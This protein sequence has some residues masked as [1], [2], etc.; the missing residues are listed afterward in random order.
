ML[1]LP[2][3]PCVVRMVEAADALSMY[4]FGLPIYLVGGALTDPDPR[5]I[6]LRVPVPDALFLA[7]YDGTEA[8][9]GVLAELTPCWRRWARDCATQSLEYTKHCRRLVD[10]KTQPQG[11][12]D[13]Y[14]DKPRVRLDRGLL[15]TVVGKY[16]PT[17]KEG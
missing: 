7:M 17:R 15:P 5:D 13:T 10:F 6:D 3:T 16:F 14:A 4:Y 11:I 2:S 1:A 12:F 8:D 9:L